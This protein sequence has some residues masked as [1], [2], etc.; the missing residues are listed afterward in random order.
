MA[1]TPD[2]N[3]L[4]I[5]MVTKACFL[6]S[7]TCVALPQS[8][9]VHPWGTYHYRP[10]LKRYWCHGCRRTFNDLTHTL[11][12]QSRRS[13]PYWFLATFVLCLPCSSRRIARELGVHIRTRD[14]W[15]W[16]LRHAALSYEMDR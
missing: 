3:S 14:R 1:E 4:C 13:R 11:L 16:W 9:D 12:A 6:A 15:C 10:G 5:H 7:I 2:I 8:H